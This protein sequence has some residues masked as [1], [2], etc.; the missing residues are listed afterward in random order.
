MR[1]LS[2]EELQQI[3]GGKSWV[4]NVCKRINLCQRIIKRS[5]K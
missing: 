5:T 3:V 2:H 1:E 4:D